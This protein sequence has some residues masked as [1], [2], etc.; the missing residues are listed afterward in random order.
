[1]D[2][3]EQKSMAFLTGGACGEPRR[4][5]EE[6]TISL[7]HFVRGTS[8]WVTGMDLLVERSYSAKGVWLISTTSCGR[9][10]RYW[11]VYYEVPAPGQ[12]R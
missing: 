1:M 4:N 3:G 11:K 8:Y 12:M 7:C 9:R 10:G 2:E 5:L 6:L